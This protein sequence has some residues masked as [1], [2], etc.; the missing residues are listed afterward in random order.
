MNSLLY[1][2]IQN[3]INLTEIW[4]GEVLYICVRVDI[5]SEELK[6]FECA[7][8]VFVEIN[9]LKAKCVDVITHQVQAISIFWIIYAMHLPKILIIAFNRNG[10]FPDFSPL[11]FQINT[12]RWKIIH[13][14]FHFD[15]I[16]L[17][18]VLTTIYHIFLLKC[19]TKSK[20]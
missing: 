5:S 8:S 1:W 13:Y 18:V 10:H 19:F 11:F 17:Y 3:L 12:L 4:V 16:V 9:L 6:F 2:V 14:N 15:F 7:W 20:Y